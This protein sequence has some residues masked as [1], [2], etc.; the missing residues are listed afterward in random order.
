M[1]CIC[2]K[3]LLG[4]GFIVNE[5][6]EYSTERHKETNI[7][8]Y[9]VKPLGDLYEIPFAE[10]KFNINFIDLQSKRDIILSDLGI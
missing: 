4:L 9:Y 1:T 10:E 5:S 8:V 2:K 7:L 6:Y 3:T